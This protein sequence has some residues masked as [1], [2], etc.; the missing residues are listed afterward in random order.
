M[1][2]QCIAG[3][4]CLLLVAGGCKKRS[5]D[6]FPASGA[7][8]GWEKTGDTRT[9]GA[10]TLWQSIDGGADKYVEAGI[11]SASTSDYRFQGRLEAVVDV[12]A[13]KDDAGAKRI[14]DSESAPGQMVA[15]GDAGVLH[16]QSIVFRKGAI[17]VRITTFEPVPGDTLLSL[18]RGIEAR[19]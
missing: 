18:A 15:V 14:F 3:C 4:L 7:V 6:P 19:L 10:D 9:Y 12:Y 17:L 5:S 2:T 1:R 16:A 11:V 8:S 13:M